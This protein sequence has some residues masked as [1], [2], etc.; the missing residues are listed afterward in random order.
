VLSFDLV[1]GTPESGD[2]PDIVA[3]EKGA[4]LNLI[5]NK[6][7]AGAD[8]GEFWARI[9]LPTGNNDIFFTVLSNELKDQYTPLANEVVFYVDGGYDTA[10]FRL[11]YPDNNS[12][13]NYPNVVNDSV[14]INDVSLIEIAPLPDVALSFSIQGADGDGDTTPV[15]DFTVYI[16]NDGAPFAYPFL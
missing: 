8:N 6:V 3:I 14:R 4:S 1:K 10:Y 5:A 15:E 13:V 12:F 16:S 9:G 2:D 11:A 7:L